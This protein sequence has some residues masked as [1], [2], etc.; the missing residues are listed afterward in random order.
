[1]HESYEDQDDRGDGHEGDPFE[2]KIDIKGNYHT[3]MITAKKK[4]AAIKWD[5]FMGTKGMAPVKKDVIPIAKVATNK[6]LSIFMSNKTYEEKKLNLVMHLGGLAVALEKNLLPVEMRVAEKRVN[7]QPH[8]VCTRTDGLRD[9]VLVD[10]GVRV[11]D[12]ICP[13]SVT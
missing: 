1:M 8:Y 11:S 7:C 3:F 4:Y 10:I 5:G 12:S 6:V 13:W 9:S 2:I